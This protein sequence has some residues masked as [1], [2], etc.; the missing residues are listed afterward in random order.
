MQRPRPPILL[1]GKGG[2]RLL[3]IAARLADGW[4]AVWR[5]TPEA[6]AERVAAARDACE[7]AGRDPSTFRLS[8]GL[9][10]IVGEDERDL[11]RRFEAIADAL[12]DGVG[13]AN[14]LETLRRECLVGT[15]EQVLERARAFAEL[16]VA[17]LILSPAPIWFA[18]PDPSMLDLIAETVLPS[19]GG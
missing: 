7:R 11:E 2:S 18:M 3:S 17:D 6:Y 4:N 16:G 19:L 5:W 12:P 15:V 1:G 8:L 9:F 14:G 10:T 13:R